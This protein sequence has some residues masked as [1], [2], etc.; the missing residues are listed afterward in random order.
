M[1]ARKILYYSNLI[2]VTLGGFDSPFIIFIVRDVSF[3]TIHCDNNIPYF[4]TGCHVTIGFNDLIQRI[5]SIYH[6]PETSF[7]NQVFN[8]DKL[9][10][11]PLWKGKENSSATEEW[12][13]H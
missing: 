9:F 8:K 4:L 2:I 13:D 10:S 11:D 5:Y 1:L 7:L 3:R 6:W 12:C